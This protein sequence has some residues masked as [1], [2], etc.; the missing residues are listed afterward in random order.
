MTRHHHH[1]Q[2]AL[3][4]S[5]RSVPLQGL[6]IAALILPPILYLIS[7]SFALKTIYEPSFA[8]SNVFNASNLPVPE[9]HPFTYKAS[10]FY[11]CTDTLSGEA[12]LD[13]SAGFNQTCKRIPAL[14]SAGMRTCLETHPGDQH[15]CQKVVVSAQLFVAGAVMI[16]LTLLGS[17][18]V[19]ALGWKGATAKMTGYAYEPAPTSEAEAKSGDHH[20]PASTFTPNSTATLNLV[21]DV[22]GTCC[23]LFAG[24]AALLLLFAQILAI[25][26]LVDGQLPSGEDATPG[27]VLSQVTQSAWYMGPGAIKH[28]STA[29]LTATIGVIIAASGCGVRGR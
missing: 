11:L 3:Q 7:L 26:A 16:G 10:P 15:F 19:V 17:F 27:V 8:L 23:M 25:N 4:S 22:L 9:P 12:L 20:S 13:A 24:L 28:A 2:Q 6:S 29:W 5:P 14:G 1:H 21:A 18:G